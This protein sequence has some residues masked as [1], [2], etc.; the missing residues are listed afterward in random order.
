MLDIKNRCL[1]RLQ[2]AGYYKVEDVVLM[3]DDMLLE[4]FSQDEKLLLDLKECTYCYFCPYS[5][6]RN[7][8]CCDNVLHRGR[9]LSSSGTLYCEKMPD[10]YP[11]KKEAIPGIP[12]SLSSQKNVS[13]KQTVINDI[14]LPLRKEEICSITP[15][16]LFLLCRNIQEHGALDSRHPAYA[17]IIL[18][19]ELQDR[20]EE[21]EFEHVLAVSQPH[22][23]HLVTMPSDKLTE[24]T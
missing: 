4:I 18:L 22:L 21:K 5:Y 6:F 15:D 17:V 13:N 10:S 23:F 20:L 19:M 14:T 24:I 12:N 16:R 3:P 2:E 9:F 7:R 11:V 1:L 8:T